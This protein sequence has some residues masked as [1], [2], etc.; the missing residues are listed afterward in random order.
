MWSCYCRNERREAEEKRKK[1][2]EYDSALGTEAVCGEK[3]LWKGV[4]VATV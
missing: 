4:V 3:R 2:K 1:S